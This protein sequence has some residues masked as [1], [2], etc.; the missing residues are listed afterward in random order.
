VRWD[1]PA[2]V[3]E[4]RIRAVTPNPGAWTLVNDLRVKVGPV[5]IDDA[6]TETL[7]P[8]AIAVQRNSVRIGTATQPVV[9]GTVQPPGKKPMDAAAWAR[10]AR[11]DD[12]AT[13]S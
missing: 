9:L 2:H 8:G 1:L 7:V 11:L 3:V 10:G 5:T 6:P 12:S 4:R 13:A